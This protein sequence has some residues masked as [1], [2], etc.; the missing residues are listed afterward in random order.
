MQFDEGARGKERVQEFLVAANVEVFTE[1]FRMPILSSTLYYAEIS[2][3][4]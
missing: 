3:I 2:K 1:I 4:L